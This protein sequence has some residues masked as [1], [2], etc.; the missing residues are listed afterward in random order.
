MARAREKSPEKFRNRDRLAAKKRE[1]NE[2]TMARAILNAAVKGGRL[3]RP[4]RCEVCGGMA[5][6]HGHHPNYSKPLAVEWLCTLC[7]G[8]K[9][10]IEFRRPSP[11]AV[12]KGA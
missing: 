9:H 10:R 7:H 12:E 11:V 8:K 4:A 5:S 1:K 6:V 3:R 2:R